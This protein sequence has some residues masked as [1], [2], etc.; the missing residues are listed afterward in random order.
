MLINYVYAWP[1]YV[2]S[3]SA[4]FRPWLYLNVNCEGFAVTQHRAESYFFFVLPQIQ[5]VGFPLDFCVSHKAAFSWF[6]YWC[7]QS[8]RRTLFS[9][10]FCR[11]RPAKRIQRMKRL[12]ALFVLGGCAFVLN[13]TVRTFPPANQ[14]SCWTRVAS[15]EP[16]CI[17][18]YS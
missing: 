13:G 8:G 9:A 16:N 17:I 5:L 6:T 7:T 2:H 3:V 1:C 15:W 10:N 4:E 12:L 18:K 14:K 11:C